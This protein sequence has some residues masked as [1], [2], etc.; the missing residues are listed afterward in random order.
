MWGDEEG[1]FVALQGLVNLLKSLGREHAVVGGRELPDEENIAKM[2]ECL[3]RGLNINIEVYRRRRKNRREHR[4]T[5]ARKRDY[6]NPAIV[7]SM[8]GCSYKDVLK[9]L[10]RKYK[11]LI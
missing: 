5:E 11:L 4:R 10:K 7:V 2:L 9:K 8:E 6:R 3:L 1:T